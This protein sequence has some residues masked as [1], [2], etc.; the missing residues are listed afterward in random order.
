MAGI[1]S[2][3][4]RIDDRDVQRT[5]QRI[6]KKSGNL[7]P[8]LKN[9]GVYL[10]ES[11]QG[12]FTR[13]VDPAGQRWAALK[14]ATLK[15]KK[16]TKILTETSG[17]RDSFVYS[18][19]NNGLKVGTNKIYA[20][21]HQFG[22]DKDLHVPAHKRRVTQAFGKELKFPVWAQVKAHTFN[23]KLPARAMLGFSNEDRRE[24]QAIA[25]DFI[26]K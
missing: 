1:F 18:V 19:R 16:H 6:E 23:P 7:H 9:M 24:L 5:L 14:P 11:I 3:V 4:E 25:E 12:R 26:A 15:Q 22:L 2:V 13:Q 21:P 20:A 10:V 17:L 8:C